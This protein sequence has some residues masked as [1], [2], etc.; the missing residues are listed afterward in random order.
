MPFLSRDADSLEVHAEVV[1]YKF[2]RVAAASVHL[3]GALK[4]HQ[5][6]SREGRPCTAAADYQ[7][8]QHPCV[9]GI[10]LQ[11]HCVPPSPV[12]Q[13]GQPSP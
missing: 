1:N 7:S 5:V 13:L 8:R 2:Q 12:T 3:H 6:I 9:A 4:A 11:S 10:K